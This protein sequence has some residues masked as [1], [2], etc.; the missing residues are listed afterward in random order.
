M[1]SDEEACNT[2]FSLSLQS[3]C[4]CVCVTAPEIATMH[5]YGHASDW[6]SLGILM[7]ALL[8]GQV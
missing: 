7:F 6:W 2:D 3:V 8:V 4:L 5:P 1:S